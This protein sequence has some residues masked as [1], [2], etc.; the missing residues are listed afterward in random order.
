L[1]GYQCLSGTFC[2]NPF[3]ANR[4]VSELYLDDTIYYGM[5]SYNNLLVSLLTLFQVLTLEGW[6]NMLYNVRKYPFPKRI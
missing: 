4:T 2:G 6:S 5:I 1:S 3:E